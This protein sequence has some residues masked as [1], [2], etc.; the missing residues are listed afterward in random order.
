MKNRYEAKE[1]HYPEIIKEMKRNG[2][3]I[4]HLLDRKGTEY[5][6]SDNKI[7]FVKIH[8]ILPQGYYLYLTT[9]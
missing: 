2:T 5:L 3:N 8:K 6:I 4:K 1:S 9:L 7:K